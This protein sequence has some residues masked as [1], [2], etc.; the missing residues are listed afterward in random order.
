MH[1]WIN[2]E[3]TIGE[4]EGY[5]TCLQT[6]ECTRCGKKVTIPDSECLA[7]NSECKRKLNFKKLKR[8]HHG[9]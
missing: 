2:H 5:M 3:F 1:K 9:K 7:D 8:R 4:W 6:Y